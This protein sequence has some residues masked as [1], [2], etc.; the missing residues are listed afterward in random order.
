MNITPD[1]NPDQEIIEA[2]QKGFF[3]KKETVITKELV[4][5]FQHGIETQ[6]LNG[7]SQKTA[8]FHTDQFAIYVTH[9]I[10][11]INPRHLYSF[12][13]VLRSAIGRH[14]WISF[15]EA[16]RSDTFIRNLEQLLNLEKQLNIHAIYCIGATNG[17][18]LGRYDIRYSLKSDLTQKAIEMILSGQHQIGLQSSYTAFEKKSVRQEIEQL[19]AATKQKPVTHR[20]HY[21]HAPPASSHA[22]LTDAGI[23]FEMGFG[24]SRQIGLKNCFPGKF[25]PIDPQT[26]RCSDITVIPMIMMDNV[27]FFRPYHEVMKRFRDTLQQVKAYNGS[28]CISFHPENMLLKPE[29]YNYFEEIIHICKEEGALINPTLN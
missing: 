3:L 6:N 24:H 13:N 25:K 29:L 28:A 8:S 22:Q 14:K 23:K 19:S 27:F 16:L 4:D 9:D 17:L 15:K 26:G 1:I 5:L 21:L 2:I 10:D 7:F 18:Q 11:W 12:A 20:C